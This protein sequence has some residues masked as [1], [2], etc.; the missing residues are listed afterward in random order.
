MR[1]VICALAY[2]LP[3]LP[4]S[5]SR[6]FLLVRGGVKPFASTAAQFTVKAIF[7]LGGFCDVLV[8]V[9]VRPG[10]LLY[11]QAASRE[12][13]R[14]PP[15]VP[16]ERISPAAIPPNVTED[17]LG[18]DL[19]NNQPKASSWYHNLN[20][21]YICDF[22]VIWLLVNALYA[23]WIYFSTNPNPRSGANKTHTGWKGF[24][25]MMYIFGFLLGLVNIGSWLAYFSA[26]FGW[27]SERSETTSSD[28]FRKFWHPAQI[29]VERVE[30]LLGQNGTESA[31]MYKIIF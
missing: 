22:V 23:V 17:H 12:A 4:T 6:W 31:P 28:I 13:H 2:V 25:V 15:H 27:L 9:L 19:A 30:T 10:Q 21:H 11:P 1:L 14:T 16:E 7:S 29:L 5:L 3:V 20:W 24:C 18:G 26:V 8:F